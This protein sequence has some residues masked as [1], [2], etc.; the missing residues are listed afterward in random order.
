[1]SKIKS[2]V[3]TTLV[4]LTMAFLIIL[5]KDIFS[6]T[7]PKEIYHILCD[8]FFVPGVC[9]AGF[10]LLVFASNEGTFDMLTF[11]M[12]KFLGLFKKDLSVYKN[13]TF[14]DYKMAK[15][16]NNRPIS[17]LLVVGLFLIIISCVF[18]ILYYQI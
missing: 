5:S 3:I 14:Y 17:F 4:G 2:Y 11:G 12:R 6:K 13:E 7:D 9:I 1:M 10:G 8:A 18:L 16:G 15:D